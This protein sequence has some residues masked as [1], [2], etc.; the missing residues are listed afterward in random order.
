MGNRFMLFESGDPRTVYCDFRPR[1][2]SENDLHPCKYTDTC[3]HVDSHTA[4]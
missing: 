4:C 3:T 2:L 1:L